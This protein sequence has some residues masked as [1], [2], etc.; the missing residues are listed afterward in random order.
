MLFLLSIISFIYS[1][2]FVSLWVG[3]QNYGGNFLLYLLI[4]AI[5]FQSIK[6]FFNKIMY[7]I[8]QINFASYLEIIGSLI[9]LITLVILLQSLENK[10]NSL[11]ISLF[12]SSFVLSIIYF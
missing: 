2:S 9:Y 3:S 12:I 10:V 8:G 11:P 6:S 4:L 7:S 1:Q 5:F